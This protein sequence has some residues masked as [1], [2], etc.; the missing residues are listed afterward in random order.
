MN[1]KCENV[2]EKTL[3]EAKKFY[4]SHKDSSNIEASF[5]Y[6]TNHPVSRLNKE[7]LLLIL[8]NIDRLQ[9][10]NEINVVDFACGGGIITSAVSRMGVKCI[11]L[12]F[13]E[14]E[15]DLAIKYSKNDINRPLFI[16]ADL[17][18]PNDKWEKQCEQYFKRKP[19][20]CILA[21]SLH[22][23]KDLDIFLGRLDQWLPKGSYLIVNE[24]NPWS[25]FFRLKHIV[26]TVVQKDTKTEHHRSINRWNKIMENNNFIN[27]NTEAVHFYPKLNI[28]YQIAWS[29]VMTYKKQ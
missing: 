23:L 4:S 22:H 11:G 21:Y 10:E 27:I 6:F 28:P 12:D 25:P 19:N 26:R 8:K 20:V 17:T 1:T 29:V 16:V 5:G 18:N 13:D 2:L 9:G 24:E 7:R 3:S 15:I 14:N